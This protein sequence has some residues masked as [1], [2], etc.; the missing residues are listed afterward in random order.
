MSKY[1]LSL[2]TCNEIGD[3]ELEHIFDKTPFY[4]DY[5]N[6]VLIKRAN[7]DSIVPLLMTDPTI[8]DQYGITKVGDVISKI[9]TETCKNVTS[10]M[11]ILIRKIQFTNDWWGIYIERRY[12]WDCFESKGVTIVFNNDESIIDT[13]YE[14]YLEKL[15]PRPI[16]INRGKLSLG[17]SNA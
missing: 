1:F 13:F 17:I 4:N 11:N 8:I 3:I 9:Q 15:Q 16:K 14:E 6:C 2:E 5:Y 10:D 12:F 7:D